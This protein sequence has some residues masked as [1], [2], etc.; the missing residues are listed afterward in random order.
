[1]LTI[2]QATYDAIV[3]HAKRDH[4]DE[5]CGIVAGPKGSDRAERLVEM[6][7][8]AGSPGSQGLGFAL[9]PGQANTF[10]NLSAIIKQITEQWKEATAR[11]YEARLR[12]GLL[13][14]RYQWVYDVTTCRVVPMRELPM[15]LGEVELNDGIEW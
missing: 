5:A 4:P 12:R 9:R 7:N 6:V 14:Y 13:A 11:D 10:I 2:D 1:M 8:A 15:G 3:A